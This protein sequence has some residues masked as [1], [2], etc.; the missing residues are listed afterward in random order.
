MRFLRPVATA[1]ALPIVIVAVW[2]AATRGTTNPFVPKPD[3]MVVDLVRTWIGPLMAQQVLPSLY[4]LGIALAAA[5]VVGIVLGLVIGTSVVARKLTG[6]I[7]EFIRA[8]PPPVLLPV[9][10][11]VMG[12]DDRSKIFLVFLGCLWPILL[13]TIDGARAADSV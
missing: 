12:I 6:P 11:L 9:L 1:L 8:V 13:N 3:L 4:R 10:L 2:W 7:F 5:I